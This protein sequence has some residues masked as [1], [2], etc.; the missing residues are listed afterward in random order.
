MKI[1]EYSRTFH[2]VKSELPRFFDGRFH[3]IYHTCLCCMDTG[4]ACFSSLRT[5]EV[6]WRAGCACRH[7]SAFHKNRSDAA[8][9]VKLLEEGAGYTER[10]LKVNEESWQAHKW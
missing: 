5:T 4:E 2:L 9:E 8:N 3:Y 6:L 1:L 10:A 7:Q